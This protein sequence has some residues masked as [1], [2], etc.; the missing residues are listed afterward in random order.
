[1]IYRFPQQ[2]KY[3]LINLKLFQMIKIRLIKRYCSKI[4]HLFLI[5]YMDVFLNN[6]ICKKVNFQRYMQLKKE[7]DSLIEELKYIKMI[8]EFMLK[9]KQK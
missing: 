4:K 3:Q 1:M 5:N 9:L 8:L 7:G 2:C 6:S